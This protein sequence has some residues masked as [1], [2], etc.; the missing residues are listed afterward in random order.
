MSDKQI[1]WCEKHNVSNGMQ[2]EQCV[3]AELI[4]GGP[5]FPCEMVP[6]RLLLDTPT[7]SGGAARNDPA[8]S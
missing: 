3:Y 7:N 8:D 1:Q 2:P 6:V 5:F 4:E